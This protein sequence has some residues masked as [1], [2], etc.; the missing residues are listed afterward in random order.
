MIVVA[1]TAQAPGNVGRGPFFRSPSLSTQMPLSLVQELTQAAQNSPLVIA[2]VALSSL[3]PLVVA[4]GTV[5]NRRRGVVNAATLSRIEKKV[6]NLSTD[7]D[8]LTGDT[9]ELRVV[10][11]G[12]DGNNGLRGD[13]R[14]LKDDVKEIT[15]RELERA[16]RSRDPLHGEYRK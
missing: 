15:K 14:E 3:S 11:I 7:I 4:A 16:E 8:D 12:V 1:T 10:I 6:E 2:A 13:V 5:W 9:R